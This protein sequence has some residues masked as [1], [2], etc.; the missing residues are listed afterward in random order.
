M[1]NFKEMYGLGNWFVIRVW[2]RRSFTQDLIIKSI[3]LKS[4]K[5]W[6]KETFFWKLLYRS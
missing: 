1:E 2:K 5:L 4:L 3:L 6:A